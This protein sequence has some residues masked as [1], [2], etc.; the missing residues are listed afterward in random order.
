MSELKQQLNL[1]SLQET[2]DATD[3][4]HVEKGVAQYH[5]PPGLAADL[6]RLLPLNRR[7]LIDLTCGRGDLLAACANVNTRHLLGI[8]LTDTRWGPAVLNSKFSIQHSPLDAIPHSVIHGGLAEVAGML[9]AAAWEGVNFVLNPPW[10]LPWRLE[11]FAFLESSDLQT[12]RDTMA[13]LRRGP[14]PISHSPSPTLDSVMA[15]L[16]VAL[17]L[18]GYHAE[19]FIIGNAETLKRHLDDRASPYRPLRDHIWLRLSPDDPRLI[20]AQPGV[21][22]ALAGFHGAGV[23]CFAV[24]HTDGP[25]N[26]NAEDSDLPDFDAWDKLRYFHR[27]GGSDYGSGNTSIEAW[28]AVRDEVKA[29]RE[30]RRTDWNLWLSPDG[31]IQTQLSVF[32]ARTVDADLAKGLYGLR[33]QR[34]MQLVMQSASRKALHTAAFHS[35]WR[36]A[37]EL[38]AAVTQAIADYQHERAPLV[39]LNPVQR[40]GYLDELTDEGLLCHTDLGSFRAGRRYSVDSKLVGVVRAGRKVNFRG[41]YDEVTYSGKELALWLYG[42]GEDSAGACFMDARLSGDDVTIT[43]GGRRDHTLQELVTHFVVPEV[44]DLAALH[45]ER[46]AAACASLR[47]L[48]ACI[49]R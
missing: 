10:G 4:K 30:A 6:A 32:D 46:H 18:G 48:E 16:M 44:P 19:G 7:E 39:P 13:N 29:R 12:V 17:T 21:V 1:G 49:R 47:E 27:L 38:Q 2:L 43:D 20:R 14:S 15:T 33:D 11:D 31:V 34:P 28:K 45:P 40:L 5:T 37:P 9:K 23:A 35:P 36:V 8:E 42:Q 24:S 3:G 41:E 25:A 22:R 26:D